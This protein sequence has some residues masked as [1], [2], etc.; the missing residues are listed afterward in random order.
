MSAAEPPPLEDIPEPTSIGAK[1]FNIIATPGDVYEE[2]RYAK[3]RVVNWLVPVLLL[4]I[5]N[6]IF[7]WIAFQNP[8]VVHGI[9]EQ[10][11]EQIRKSMARNPKMTEEKIEKA[12]EGAKKFMT[13]RIMAMF[14][15]A[16]ATGAV[17]VFL[18]AQGFVLWV[19]D[20]F[21]L[22]TNTDFMRFVEISGVAQIISVLSAIARMFIVQATG[23]VQLGT[24]LALLLADFDPANPVHLLINNLELFFLWYLGVVALGISTVTRASLVKSLVAVAV[25]WVL[26]ASLVALPAF[27]AH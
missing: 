17:M 13:P 10:Q 7:T 16:G 23:E 3:P 27:L 25:F 6:S 9:Q 14:G 15:I 26:L 18:F 4:M 1:L 11:A 19:V 8:A 12:V 22:R 24:S 2:M 5:A 21:L 20:R